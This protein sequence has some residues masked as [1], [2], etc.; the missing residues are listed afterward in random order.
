VCPG[1][2]PR[3]CGDPGPDRILDDVGARFDEVALVLDDPA[4][5]AAGEQRAETDVL[6]VE[7]LRVASVQALQPAGQVRLGR[8][9]DQVVVR[10][11]EA[12]RM[13]RP[14]VT[15]RAELDEPQKRAP[16]VVVPEDR[17][18]VDATREDV[19]VPIRQRCAKHA[20]HAVHQSARHAQP[21]ACG[22]TGTLSAR[23][24]PSVAD[25]ARV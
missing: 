17:A 4:L 2:L 8:V 7:P 11:H 6:V 13:H 14:P 15:V 25:K 22:A 3:L 5:E 12:Q 19:E 9:Q 18:A 23:L 24:H 20:R 1:P 10:R 16:V 21:P